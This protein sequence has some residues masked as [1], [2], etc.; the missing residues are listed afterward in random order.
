M[1]VDVTQEDQRLYPGVC[2]RIHH[3][4]MMQLTN[5]LKIISVILLH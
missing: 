4:P 3:Q 2:H 1:I 5:P